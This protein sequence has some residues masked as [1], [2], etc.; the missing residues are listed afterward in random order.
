M[1]KRKKIGDY[2]MENEYMR[3]ENV[4]E[5]EIKVWVKIKEID[6]IK[7]DME[8]EVEEIKGIKGYDIK[9]IM[10][11]GKV[12]KIDKRNWEMR[13]K[14]GKVK[15]IQKEREVEIEMEQEKIE[16]NGLSLSVK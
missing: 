12:E 10:R 15:R 11:K 1:S 6:E 5:D 2:V 7:V 8:E 4:M 3:E 13:E 14:R 16:E 9:K